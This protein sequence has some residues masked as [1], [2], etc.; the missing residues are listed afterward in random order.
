MLDGAEVRTRDNDLFELIARLRPR[1]DDT[2]CP[3]ELLVE[4]VWRKTRFWLARCPGGVL[5]TEVWSGLLHRLPVKRDDENLGV[6]LVKA[7][8]NRRIHRGW[9]GQ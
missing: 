2:H 7:L 6:D 8:G 3:A 5:R 1:V 4:G 9:F